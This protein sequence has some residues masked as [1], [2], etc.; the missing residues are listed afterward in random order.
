MISCAGLE[1]SE[2]LQQI[3]WDRQRRCA[4]SARNQWESKEPAESRPTPPSINLEW[5]IP[6]LVQRFTSWSADRETPFRRAQTIR[7]T[8]CR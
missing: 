2:S 1:C 4:K 5:E 7:H 6:M 8:A 3:S